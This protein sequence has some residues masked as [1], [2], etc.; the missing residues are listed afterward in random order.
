[1][2]TWRGYAG[3]QQADGVGP[4][5]WCHHR[6][7]PQRDA[8]GAEAGTGGTAGAVLNGAN[9]EAVG[10]FLA[11]KIGFL[12]I[13]AKVEKALSQVKAVGNPTMQDILDADEAARAAVV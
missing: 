13:P 1:M 3:G 12:D 6:R 11:G 10:Q 2:G 7:T 9:E 8:A 5:L 4:V